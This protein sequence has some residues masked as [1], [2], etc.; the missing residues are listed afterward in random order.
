MGTKGPACSGEREAKPDSKYTAQ[1]QDGSV[2]ECTCVYT[3]RTIVIFVQGMSCKY[4][5]KISWSILS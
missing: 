4:H 2:T 5:L 1:V 3:L